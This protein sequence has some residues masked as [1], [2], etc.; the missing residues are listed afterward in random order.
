MKK[1]IIKNILIV[2]IITV[3]CSDDFV[4]VAFPDEIS[5]EF[6]NSEQDY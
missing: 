3:S 2:F 1:F 5:D 4:D 6:F